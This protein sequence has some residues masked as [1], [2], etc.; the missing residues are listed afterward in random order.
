M[1]QGPQLKEEPRKWRIMKSMRKY[2]DSGVG[3]CQ[4]DQSELN[5]CVPRSS[6]WTV[7]IGTLRS[8]HIDHFRILAVC[9]K[10]VVGG[11]RGSAIGA[12]F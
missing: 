6:H 3:E 1:L 12:Q 5:H 4:R 7:K 2:Q 8:L 10:Q 9:L 11:S